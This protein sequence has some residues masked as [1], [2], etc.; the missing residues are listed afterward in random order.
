MVNFKS[1]STRTF[2]GQSRRLQSSF[3]AKITQTGFHFVT[4]VSTKSENLRNSVHFMDKKNKNGWSFS[5]AF[6]YVI[7]WSF[8][9]FWFFFDNNIPEKANI[10]NCGEQAHHSILGFWCEW[11]ISLFFIVQT[12]AERPDWRLPDLYHTVCLLSCH[13][14]SKSLLALYHIHPHVH[15]NRGFIWPSN[16]LSIARNI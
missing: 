9:V 11:A 6:E 14:P 12:R 4:P 15:S 1:A 13:R 7:F 8:L 16:S 2:S 5:F 3:Y 10:W